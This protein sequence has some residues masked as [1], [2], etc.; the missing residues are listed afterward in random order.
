MYTSLVMEREKEGFVIYRQL[1]T[2][3]KANKLLKCVI[4]IKSLKCYYY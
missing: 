1:L 3:K 4:P 2:L